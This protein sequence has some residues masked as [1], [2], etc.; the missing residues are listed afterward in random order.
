M[1]GLAYNELPSDITSLKSL[2]IE[3]DRHALASDRKII[4]LEAIVA[5]LEEREAP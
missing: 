4:L 3:R 2:L 1:D 5:K